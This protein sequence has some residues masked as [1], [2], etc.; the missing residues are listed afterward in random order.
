MGK[1]KPRTPDEELY[2][3]ERI[4]GRKLEN[5]HPVYLIQWKGYE[6][7]KHD[8]WEPLSNLAG[9]EPDVAAYEAKQRKD[10]LDFAAEL[11]ISYLCVASPVHKRAA[12]LRVCV[13][14]GHS[15]AS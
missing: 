3:V 7:E 4:K 11:L 6:D 5:G 9:I 2:E 10:A 1:R 8:T 14:C 12:C 15:S 13:A